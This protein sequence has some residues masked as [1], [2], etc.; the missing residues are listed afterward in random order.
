M[1]KSLFEGAMQS[2]H[3]EHEIPHMMFGG[4]RPMAMACMMAAPPPP[5]M[6]NSMS[7]MRR[8]LKKCTE[9]ASNVEYLSQDSFDHFDEDEAMDY[10]LE[11]DSTP[12]EE[13]KENVDGMKPVLEP[14][15]NKIIDLQLAN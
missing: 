14:G 3:I 8:S 11:C 10:T 15:L 2:R 9:K 1:G 7:L 6:C 13:I 5:L 4:G 12:P